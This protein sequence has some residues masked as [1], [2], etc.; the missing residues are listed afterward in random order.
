MGAQGHE[1]FPGGAQAAVDGGTAQVFGLGEQRAAAVAR[2]EVVVALV[3]LDPARVVGVGV[4]AVAG[5]NVLVFALD[6]C[7]LHAE[8]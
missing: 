4:D 3:E 2:R 8:F 7:S 5:E 1:L 6:R